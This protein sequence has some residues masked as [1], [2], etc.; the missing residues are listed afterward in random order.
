ME[1]DNFLNETKKD[2]KAGMKRH[3]RS[4]PKDSDESQS[5]LGTLM[6]EAIKNN[7]VMFPFIEDIHRYQDAAAFR[8]S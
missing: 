1:L 2:L 4:T 7:L 3:L 5:A 8:F 6:V